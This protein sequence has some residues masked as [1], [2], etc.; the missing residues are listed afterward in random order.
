[1]S[2]YQQLFDE[3]YTRVVGQGVGITKKGEQFFS[4]FYAYF[5]ERSDE[6]KR[7][8][9]D[10]DMESQVGILQKSMYHMISF[11]VLHTDHEFLRRIATTHNQSHYDIKPEYYDHW[12][13]ALIST[14]GELDPQFDR[15]TELAWRLAVT[16]GILYLKMHYESEDIGP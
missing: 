7:K 13:E 16:P 6:I 14:V 5:F 9:K 11:Y 2:N 3:S 4:R 10:T 12:L 15:E 1:M 8:F